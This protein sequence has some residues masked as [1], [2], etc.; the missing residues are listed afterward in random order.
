MTIDECRQR[1]GG[2]VFYEPE[3]GPREQGTITC[4]SKHFAFVRFEG[5]EHAKAVHPEDLALVEDAAHD[6]RQ[7]GDTRVTDRNETLHDLAGVLAAVI[8]R[9]D[10]SQREYAERLRARLGLSGDGNADAAERALRPALAIPGPRTVTFD[11]GD[12]DT[13]S[14]LTLALEEL[15]ASQRERARAGHGRAVRRADRA[16]EMHRQVTAAWERRDG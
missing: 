1:I 15:S 16:D 14:V 11:T 13:Y 6:A 9:D 12:W 8:T 7:E 10:V 5:G 4:V 2:E 3:G